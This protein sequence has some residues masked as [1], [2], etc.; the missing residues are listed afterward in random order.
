MADKERLTEDQVWD[1]LSFAQSLYNGGKYGIYSPWTQNDLLVGLNNLPTTAP[2][3][4]KIDKALSKIPV[5]NEALQR[6]S[7]FFEVFDMIYNKL[8]EYYEGLLSFDLRISCKNYKDPKEFSSNA[9]KQDLKR[10]YKFLDSFSYK[11]EFRKAVRQMLRTDVA[12]YW[13]RDSEG[14][15]NDDTDALDISKL[16]NF[17]LQILPQNQCKITGYC[18]KS[19][20]IFDFNMDYFLGANVDIRLY[21]PWFMKAY[22]NVFEKQGKI[23]YVPHSQLK[24]RNGMYASWVQ[25]SPTNGAWCFKYNIGNFSE[26]PPLAGLFRTIIDNDT[27]AK[28]QIDKDLISAYYLL[29]GEIGMI[30]NAKSGEKKNMTKFDPKALGQFMGLVTNGLKNNVKAT[31]MPL[32]NIRGWQFTDSNPSSANTQNSMSAGLGSSASSLIFTT[33]TMGQAELQNA[34][35]TDYNKMAKLYPQFEEFLNFFV[36]KK[37]K[38]YKFSFKFTGS[39]YQFERESRQT[40]LKD[41]AS[42]GLTLGESAWASAYGFEPQEF[43]RLL[44]EGHNGELQDKLTLMGNIYNM[45][46]GINNNEKIG[47]KKSQSEKTDK[48]VEAMDNLK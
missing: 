11:Q 32:E 6:Y 1:T 13:F 18:N 20:P 9:Y 25:T 8:L 27:V 28:L 35:L 14:T 22:R 29:A 4:E 39:N 21:D 40:A 36:N 24:D 38:K 37:T 30:D 33:G 41:M 42:I 16:R 34:I 5:D 19:T 48:S 15:Y 26:T 46:N 17:T 23:S 45:Q 7:E 10:V 3:H 12:Y 47:N 44:D 2:T 43:S 31:A